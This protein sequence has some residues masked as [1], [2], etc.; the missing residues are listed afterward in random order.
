MSLIETTT[1]Q[2]QK[3][4]DG[5]KQDHGDAAQK[6]QHVET[7]YYETKREAEAKKD[8]ALLREALSDTDPYDLR[9]LTPAQ[10]EAEADKLLGESE[11]AYSSEIPKDQE[12]VD[13]IH[14]L[15]PDAPID[16]D[17]DGFLTEADFGIKSKW[18]IGREMA[19]RVTLD[20]DYDHDDNGD[21]DY[22]SPIRIKNKL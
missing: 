16:Y 12:L 10:L 4:F 22:M 2:K 11:V 1:P 14:E 19:R 6:K 20:S 5:R 17:N 21:S 8:K 3:E 15:D 7:F 18:E 9:S 13:V